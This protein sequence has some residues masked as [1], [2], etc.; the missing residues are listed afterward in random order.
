MI[1]K[2]SPPRL[3][4]FDLLY[5]LNIYNRSTEKHI[6]YFK[7]FKVPFCAR[8]IKRTYAPL[9]F[10]DNVVSTELRKKRRRRKGLPLSF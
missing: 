1:Q 10:Y 5:C 8:N 2:R 4:S 6:T 7:I 9:S 3:K